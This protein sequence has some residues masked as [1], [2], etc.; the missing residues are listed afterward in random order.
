MWNPFLRNVPRCQVTHSSSVALSSWYEWMVVDVCWTPS[1]H[2]SPT[3]TMLPQ[4]GFQIKAFAC[5]QRSAGNCFKWKRWWSMLGWEAV[6]EFL[7]RS[8]EEDRLCLDNKAL[9]LRLSPAGRWGT[10]VCRLLPPPFVWFSRGREKATLPFVEWIT[11][12]L[13][14]LCD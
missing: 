12:V 2:V 14:L 9:Q 7:G 3:E 4:F 11:Q 8:A 10:C 13:K 6:W 5:W 1:P